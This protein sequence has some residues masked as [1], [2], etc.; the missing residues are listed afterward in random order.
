MTIILGIV[1]GVLIQ[2]YVKSVLGYKE[3][4]DTK[5]KE[6]RIFI[7]VVV[8][9]A[10]YGAFSEYIL[11]NSVIT[12]LVLFAFLALCLEFIF[13][14]TLIE[15]VFLSSQFTFHMLLSKGISI[16]IIA[17]VDN[18]NIYNVTIMQY[19]KMGVML[20]VVALT[21]LIF[22]GFCYIFSPKHTAILIENRSK[23][24]LLTVAQLILNI[25]LCLNSLSYNYDID[26]RWF[27]IYHLTIYLMLGVVFYTVF[28][29]FVNENKMT[30]YKIGYDIYQ[31]Q[32]KKQIESFNTQTEY[33]KSM[34]KFKHDYVMIKKLLQKMIYNSDVSQ[35][36]K[37]VV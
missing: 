37:S 19:Q 14:G 4:I 18:T 36:R 3:T 7:I 12:Y 2:K 28:I 26:H 30:E 11:Q 10:I 13:S 29:Y 9:S 35:D 24:R 34:R 31:I 17:I 33:I 25:L 21:L 32:L 6:I 16:S 1:L 22:S 23:L 8:I 20:T 15:H 27:S 5:Y